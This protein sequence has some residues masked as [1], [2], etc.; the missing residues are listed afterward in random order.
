MSIV[1]KN[2]PALTLQFLLELQGQDPGPLDGVI[3]PKTIAALQAFQT[4]HLLPPCQPAAA[5]DDPRTG[6]ALH[7]LPTNPGARAIL[8]GMTFLGTTESPPN[9]NRT[10]FGEWF[11]DNGVPWCA[12]FVS[13]CFVTSCGITLCSGFEGKGVKAGKGCAYVPTIQNW[14]IANHLTVDRMTIQPGDILIYTWDG[15]TP[16]HIGLS[17]GTPD[18]HGPDP[19][20]GVQSLE[21]NTSPSSD[22]DGGEVLLRTRYLRNI[23]T[24]GRI[25]PLQYH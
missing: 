6:P 24:I 19:T 21:G 16:Q 3:G 10:Q 23:L 12:I 20:G 1:S 7:N 8:S 18:I 5:L 14:L 4:G 13:Y 2:S 25:P 15:K 17:C 22:S 9:S 11:E